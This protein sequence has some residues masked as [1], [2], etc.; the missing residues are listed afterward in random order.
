MMRSVALT[1]T[2]AF[3]LA[4]CGLIPTPSVD[5]QDSRQELPDSS[6]LGGKVVY[7]D[8]DALKDNRVPSVL[9]QVTVR[10][11]A[12]YLSGA[13][14]T[15]SKLELFV[16]PDLGNLPATCRE[17]AASVVA[18]HMFVCDAD[19]EKAQSIGTLTLNRGQGVAFTLSG[20]AL[21]AAARGGHGYFGLRFTE[22]RSLF[23]DT[24]T[25]TDMKASARL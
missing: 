20:A 2:A 13:G 23:G 6:A 17:Y 15:L 24:L 22:G 1:L 11:N 14:G 9:Q 7:L 19:G 3:L 10:G 16:R 12:T 5:I 8:Q 18:P 21:D 25:L 4:G